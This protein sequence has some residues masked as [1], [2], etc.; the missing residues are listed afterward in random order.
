MHAP[1]L[2]LSPEAGRELLRSL[3]DEA[4]RAVDPLSS[5]PRHLPPRPRGRTV[6]VGAGKAAARMALALERAWDGPLSGLVV[7]RY[8]HGEPC[9]RI[10]V[11][12]AGHPVPDEAGQQAAQR[13]RALVQGLGA[14]DLVIA[15]ISGGG[16]SLLTAPAP[17][18]TLAEKREL[19]N[20]LLHSGATIHEMNC[21]RKHLSSIKGGKL[22]Q[23]SGAAAVWTLV[24]SD[25]PGD[26]PRTVASGPTLPD[27]STPQ[28]ALA[29]LRQY[30]I[31]PSPAVRQVLESP[32]VTPAAA[33]Q[34]PREVRVIATAQA[35]LDAAAEAAR[36]RGLRPLVLGNAIEGEARQVGRVH[37]GIARQVA[38][39]GQPLAAPA[40]LLSGGET[41]VTV[42]GR[43]RGGRNAEFLLGELIGLAGHP[44]VWGLAADTDGIDG[45][46]SNAGALFGPD[47]WARGLQQG[48]SAA[49]L[50]AGNDAFSYFDALGDLVVTGPTRTNV[51]DFRA[52]LIA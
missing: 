36:A 48:L 38:G 11:V 45:S 16:S 52:T 1:D 7:T 14:Q 3:F 6:V 18:L 21:V 13:I 28:D 37:A 33:Q 30:G 51:N 50:L 9:Q 26:D 40:V 27:D 47:S 23:A 42:T 24:V 25:V 4:L 2:S 39:F 43:G 20:R 35:A 46:E 5:V 17:G 12:E 19:T 41:T 34:G 32:P 29:V 10:E 31:T 8:G 15:L 44:R 49:D 22:A